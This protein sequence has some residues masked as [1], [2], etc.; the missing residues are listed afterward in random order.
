MYDEEVVGKTERN[1]YFVI[2]KVLSGLLPK[3]FERIL[4]LVFPLVHLG[5]CTAV[6]KQH[7][8]ER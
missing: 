3:S 1:I 2:Q 6:E 4:Y 7:Q 5:I 8:L